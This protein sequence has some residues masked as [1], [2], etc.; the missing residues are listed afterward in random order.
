MDTSF[1]GNMPHSRAGND[2]THMELMRHE[3]IANKIRSIF[4]VEILSKQNQLFSLLQLLLIR[5]IIMI[6]KL[7]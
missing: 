5:I 6:S 1:N 3:F 4:G 2:H 7:P